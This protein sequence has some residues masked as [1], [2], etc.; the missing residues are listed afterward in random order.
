MAGNTMNAGSHTR[1][2]VVF[3]LAGALYGVDIAQVREIIRVPDITRV[4]K[5]ADFVEGIINLR[6]GVIPV[7]NLR[8]RFKLA[9]DDAAD[10]ER[11]VI[12]E[13]GGELIGIRVDGVSEVLRIDAD[14]VEP[15]S[16]YIVN[17]D[18]QFV[19]GIA[20]VEDDL[21]VLLDLKLLLR[22][23]EQD[24]LRQATAVAAR[25]VS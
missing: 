6:G 3:S 25:I 18:T 7:L 19:V 12:V 9:P 23:S 13:L 22:P 24:E 16:Q 8:S 17:V 2:L 1:Q 11:I 21:I 14:L 5:T 10:E 4:P 15:P 20:R